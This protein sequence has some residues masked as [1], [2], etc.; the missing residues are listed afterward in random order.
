VLAE[1]LAETAVKVTIKN[2]DIKI[3]IVFF[4]RERFCSLYLF[5]PPDFA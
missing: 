4:I 5:H 2:I 3:L 1:A